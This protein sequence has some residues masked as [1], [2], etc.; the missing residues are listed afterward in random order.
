[1]YSTYKM[2]YKLDYVNKCMQ[3]LQLLHLGA[4]LFY[5]RLRRK[6]W[7]FNFTKSFVLYFIFII[8]RYSIS[9]LRPPVENHFVKWAI[10][11]KNHKIYIFI[12]I[13]IMIIKC[14]MLLFILMST[15]QGVGLSHESNSQD[16]QIVSVRSHNQL[17]G[18]KSGQIS[19]FFT[20]CIVY[21][22]YLEI[23]RCLHE[24]YSFTL[25]F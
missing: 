19:F 13:S 2:W 12:I 14:I 18:M 7:V 17:P 20:L 22:I 9:F 11:L 1:M 10:C 23:H 3:L 6:K 5:D 16:L 24:R 4:K 15:G 21:S 8:W 25:A